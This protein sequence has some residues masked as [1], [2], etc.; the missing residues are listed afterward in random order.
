M[1]KILEE[2]KHF[3]SLVSEQAYRIKKS[4]KFQQLNSEAQWFKEECLILAQKNKELI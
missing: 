1:E 4:E 3:R 2:L